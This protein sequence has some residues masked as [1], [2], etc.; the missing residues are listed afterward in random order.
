MKEFWR[1]AIDFEN[2]ASWKCSYKIEGEVLARLQN[3]S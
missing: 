1:F 2:F 3:I